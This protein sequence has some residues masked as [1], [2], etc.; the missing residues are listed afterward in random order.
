MNGKSHRLD[1]HFQ[2]CLEILPGEPALFVHGGQYHISSCETA[3]F[4]LVGGIVIGRLYQAGNDGR[5]AP[6]KLF[7]RFAKIKIG[8]F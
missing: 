3:F 1:R 8:S 5:F 2:V 6:G 7:Y 4:V